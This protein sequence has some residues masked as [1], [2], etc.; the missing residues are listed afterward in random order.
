M[1]VCNLSGVP[2]TEKLTSRRMKPEVYIQLILDN[3]GIAT[4]FR[5]NS[6]HLFS[7]LL[8]FSCKE[9]RRLYWHNCM[10]VVKTAAFNLF[11]QL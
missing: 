1:H 7:L 5:I 3:S 4:I 6:M 11:L 2:M 10:Y 8:L 9:K